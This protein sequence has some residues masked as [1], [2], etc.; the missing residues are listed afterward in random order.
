MF[1]VF[2]LGFHCA[3]YRQACFSCDTCFLQKNLTWIK[4]FFFFLQENA[5]AFV[6]LTIRSPRWGHGEAVRS[7]E[8]RWR[9]QSA[10][11][12]KLRTKGF[13]GLIC[14]LLRVCTDFLKKFIPLLTRSYIVFNQLVK[15]FRNTFSICWMQTSSSR[16]K[17]GLGVIVYSRRS[18]MICLW[19]IKVLSTYDLESV[20][21]D[22]L[23]FCCFRWRSVPLCWFWR[24]PH[25][26]ATVSNHLNAFKPNMPIALSHVVTLECPSAAD[27]IYV[28][29]PNC[30]KT[31]IVL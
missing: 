26:Q 11:F 21:S 7:V 31:L 30:V 8:Q 27:L 22:L 12:T 23:Q 29:E 9:T 16:V 13:L 15:K 3:G 6:H 14:P 24:I 10:E 19:V 20:F 18:E 28:I 2:A 5:V 4:T 1:K 25:G 17:V